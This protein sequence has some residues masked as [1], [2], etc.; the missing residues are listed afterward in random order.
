ML[1]TKRRRAHQGRAFRLRAVQSFICFIGN[2]T[3]PVLIGI[4]VLFGGGFVIYRLVH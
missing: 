2:E 1:F 3:A 4:P